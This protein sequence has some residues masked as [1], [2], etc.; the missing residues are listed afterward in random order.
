[1]ELRWSELEPKISMDPDNQLHAPSSSHSLGRKICV[2][3][4]ASAEDMANFV[5]RLLP[6]F[7]SN[8]HL[9]C[10]C[11]VQNTMLDIRW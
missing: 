6:E 8:K 11:Y 2:D 4:L 10:P 5:T 9:S 1:M 3:Q 7:L